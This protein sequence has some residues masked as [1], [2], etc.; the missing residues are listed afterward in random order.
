[1]PC[2]DAILFW[3]QIFASVQAN[4]AVITRTSATFFAKRG[5]HAQHNSSA[6]SRTNGCPVCEAP[7]EV[8]KTDALLTELSGLA[9]SCQHPGHYYAV[10]D[11][12]K[13]PQVFVMAENGEVVGTINI[14][15]ISSGHRFGR[16]GHG[17]WEAVSV[18]PC[19]VQSSNSS[20][21]CHS[22][23]HCVYVADIGHNCARRS[24]NCS[25][26]RDEYSII[27]LQEPDVL[28]SDMEIQG[29]RLRFTYP[30][31]RHDGESLMATP[32]GELYVLSKTDEGISSLYSLVGIN[33]S[34]MITARRIVN[35]SV[36]GEA[37]TSGEQRARFF[38][39]AALAKGM[40]GT[41]YGITLRTQLA[42]MYFPRIANGSFKDTL[43]QPACKLPSPQLVQS[44]VLTWNQPGDP[45][46]FLTS[47]E[48][49]GSP[50]MKV[51]C[52]IS[53]FT[54]K[55]GSRRDSFRLQVLLWLAAC[56]GLSGAIHAPLA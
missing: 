54:V 51:R 21:N 40:D 46:Y 8:G 6:L 2:V 26:L 42:V 34:T 19:G 15:N 10:N 55:S 44:E 12:P 39:D 48:K 22:G 36:S 50:V 38:S 56:I 20:S 18:G 17:D 53:N 7:E 23:A 43:S 16:T 45:I 32:Q 1:M 35:V 24:E 3:L 25:F 27:K 31:G 33:P 47:S 37:L 11:S 14:T 52:S 28:N 4:H 13:Y 9:A 41:I 30:D 49:P 29:V 5:T